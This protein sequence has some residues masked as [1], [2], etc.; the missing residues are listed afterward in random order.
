MAAGAA[1]GVDHEAARREHVGHGTVHHLLHQRGRPGP[2]GLVDAHPIVLTPGHDDPAERRLR[3]Q[4]GAAD[5][6]AGSGGVVEGKPGLRQRRGDLDDQGGQCVLVGEDRVPVLGEPVE[7]LAEVGQPGPVL[8]RGLA[9]EDAVRAAD[10]VDRPDA[11]GVLLV[12]R[13]LGPTGVGPMRERSR[14]DPA[15]TVRLVDEQPPAL[16]DGGVED[17]LTAGNTTHNTHRAHSMNT[18]SSGKDDRDRQPWRT[19]ET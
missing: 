16:T 18:P 17:D 3:D 5:L 8:R 11:V 15:R 7:L 12:E 9:V 4:A 10:S 13:R 19:P 14:E 1:E 2:V 6:A